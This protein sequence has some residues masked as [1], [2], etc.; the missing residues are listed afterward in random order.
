MSEKEAGLIEV[1]PTELYDAITIS[2]SKDINVTAIIKW[3]YDNNCIPIPCQSRKKKPILDICKHTVLDSGFEYGLFD[4]TYH[5]ASVDRVSWINNFWNRWLTIIEEDKNLIVELYP[6]KMS[7]AFNTGNG[8]NNQ[9]FLSAIDIDD[10]NYI[11]DFNVELFKDC[12]RIYGKAGVKI[13]FFSEGKIHQGIISK[14]KIGKEHIIDIFFSTPRLI[15]AYGEHPKST[16]EE[17]ICYKIDELKSIPILNREQ[18]MEFINL[19]V[20]EKDFTL[21]IEK[22]KGDVIKQQPLI[23]HIGV[24]KPSLTKWSN[25]RLTDIISATSNKIAHPVHGSDTG[26]NVSLNFHDDTWFC[27]RCKSGG[28]VL[29]LVAV[30]EG[31]ID[32]SDA[33]SS[34]F[35]IKSQRNIDQWLD[36]KKVLENKYGVDVFGYEIAI[37]K[38]YNGS[39]K[40]MSD[41]WGAK[42]D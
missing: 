27:H 34:L 40:L 35:D 39:K 11:N 29:E 38:W 33:Q 8:W 28:G 23:N 1:N 9:Q 7:I 3:M 6:N 20:K 30:V 22:D 14:D 2:T 24:S 25:L 37:R 41:V 5:S 12:P 31:I 13:L 19:Y 36:L 32:C 4:T 10:V 16:L 21:K 15:F 17:P 26:Y 18:V 42:I